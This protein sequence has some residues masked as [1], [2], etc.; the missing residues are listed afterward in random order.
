MFRDRGTVA[1]IRGAAGNPHQRLRVVL[2]PHPTQ[3]GAPSP[4]TRGDRMADWT[5]LR[6]GRATR[7]A[8]GV[9]ATCRRTSQ[10]TA[11]GPLTEPRLLSH[12]RHSAAVSLE[13]QESLS[14]HLGTHTFAWLPLHLH[15]Q[16]TVAAG[17]WLRWA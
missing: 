2:A 5:G 13:S 9:S 4:H 16:G 3:A 15:P 7:P 14:L 8:P 10:R 17:V 6:G 12:V 1:W 11:G